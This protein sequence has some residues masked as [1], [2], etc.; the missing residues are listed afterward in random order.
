LYPRI[1]QKRGGQQEQGGDSQLCPYERVPIEERCGG[2]GRG[3]EEGY[4][5]DE[6]AGAPPE[7]RKA[8]GAR[9]GEEKYAR[10]PHC[11]LPEF[12]MGLLT[13]GESAYSGRQ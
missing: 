2:V 11:S 13:G 10:R 1:H 5:D 9:L 6:R 7:Q 12:K 4:E 8:E 3:P